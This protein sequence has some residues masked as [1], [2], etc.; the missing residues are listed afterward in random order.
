MQ[1]AIFPIKTRPFLPPKD[2]LYELLDTYLPLV[3]EGDILL[4]TSKILA[5]HQGRTI[6]IT[7][8]V[9]KDDLIMKEA[10][11]FIPREESLNEQVL[12][13]I[14]GYTLIPSAGIDE[15]N[16]NGYYVLWPERIQQSAKEIWD[17]IKE[18]HRIKKFGVI[19]TDS[20]TIPLRRG[21]IGISIGF[22]GLRPIRDYR[23]TKDIFGRVLK[24]TQV[25]TLDALASLGVLMMGEGNEQ[26]PLC[27]LRGANFVEFTDS[28]C[29]ADLVIPE[30]EDIYAPLLRVFRKKERSDNA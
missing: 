29:Y 22:Y 11:Q 20:H 9:S 10:E 28:D 27:I 2:N 6:K 1:L 8:V 5:I 17:Y 25:D 15:S 12:L 18:K 3:E 13:T 23:G 24:I 19:I 30:Y 14:K 16:A 21:V 26:T 7:D 4:V